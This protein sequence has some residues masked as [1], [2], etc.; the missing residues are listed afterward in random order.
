MQPKNFKCFLKQSKKLTL[1]SRAFN[2]ELGNSL[3]YI[4]SV[5]GYDKMLPMNSGADAVEAALKICRK[6]G[7]EVKKLQKIRRKLLFVMVIF[8]EEQQ[9]L[10]HFRQVKK[11][12]KILDR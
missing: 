2:N 8:T 9:Q 4:T 7:Y 1:T 11:V 10:F 6:W 5:F 12:K 3:E